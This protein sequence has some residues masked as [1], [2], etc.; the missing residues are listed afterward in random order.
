M[1]TDFEE[2]EEQVVAIMQRLERMRECFIGSGMLTME[3]ARQMHRWDKEHY[4]RKFEDA[5]CKV[6]CEKACRLKTRHGC[7][8]W[9]L[10]QILN[11][12]KE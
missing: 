1:K 7:V 3:A 4:L 9:K 5:Y 10:E 8:C 6:V 11:I 2:S 12:V